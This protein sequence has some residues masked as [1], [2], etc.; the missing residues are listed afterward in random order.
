MHNLFGVLTEQ[1]SEDRFEYVRTFRIEDSITLTTDNTG[2][3]KERGLPTQTFKVIKIVIS[4]F[5]FDDVEV[6]RFTLDVYHTQS[7]QKDNRITYTDR[8]ILVG[9][10]NILVEHGFPIVFD[11]YLEWSE[12]DMQSGRIMNF[13]VI[14]HKVWNVSEIEYLGFKLVK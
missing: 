7:K 4:A 8:G 9:L 5:V 12:L 6:D 14:S 10:Y 13:D 1:H 3:W 11:H 2:R